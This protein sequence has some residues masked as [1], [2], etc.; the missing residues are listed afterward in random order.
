MSTNGQSVEDGGWTVAERQVSRLR[1]NVQEA[2]WDVK[3]CQRVEQETARAHRQ[4]RKALER[5]LGRLATR[6]QDLATFTGED[7]DTDEGL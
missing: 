7:M 6:R 3:R 2:V 5:A 4:A 1:G